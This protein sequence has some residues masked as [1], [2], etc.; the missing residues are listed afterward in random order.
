MKKQTLL[1]L[2]LLTNTITSIDIRGNKLNEAG[3]ST[4]VQ[5]IETTSLRYLGIDTL[6]VTKKHN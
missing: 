1:A 6:S 2:K 3:I 4:I 5:H